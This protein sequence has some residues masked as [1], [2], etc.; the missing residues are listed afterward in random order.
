MIPFYLSKSDLKQ[1]YI[2]LDVAKFIKQIRICNSYTNKLCSNLHELTNKKIND[3]NWR[4]DYKKEIGY[5]YYVNNN[6]IKDI[7]LEIIKNNRKFILLISNF[8]L[9]ELELH[10]TELHKTELHKTELQPSNELQTKIVELENEINRIQTKIVELENEINRIQKEI[11]D[12]TKDDTETELIEAID[13]FEE[14]ID[15]YLKKAHTETQNDGQLSIVS[16]KTMRRHITKS[17]I[18]FCNSENE[19][20]SVTMQYFVDVQQVWMNAMSE[21]NPE[22]SKNIYDKG[23]AAVNADLTARAEEEARLNEEQD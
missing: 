10:K 13:E 17:V 7:I 12:N 3:H 9:R 16:L 19:Y 22:V 6:N 15:T 1:K 2:K 4:H 5:E 23:I 20:E 21:P 18:D 8:Q 14:Q 11:Q